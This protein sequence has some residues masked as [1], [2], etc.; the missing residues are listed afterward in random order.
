MDFKSWIKN[1]KNKTATFGIILIIILVAVLWFI[2]KPNNSTE[3]TE[4]I[5]DATLKLN[6]TEKTDISDFGLDIEKI[7]VSVPIIT[8]VDD[9]NETEYLKA[10]E[11]GVALSKNYTQSPNENGNLFIFG[12][13]RYYRDKPGN[14]KEI[15]AKLNEMKKGD[16]FKL[17]Y[18]KQAFTYETTQSNIVDSGDWNITKGPTPKDNSDKTLTLMTCWP[19]GTIENRWIVYAIQK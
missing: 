1:K 16:K 2:Y 11:N 3:I 18:K 8:G 5:T 4:I 10:I 17:Y 12:H 19:P 15:F 14:Y 13:S 9:K 6:E 7:N